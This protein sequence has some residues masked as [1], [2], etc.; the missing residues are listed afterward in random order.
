MYGSSRNRDP[1]LAM[2]LSTRQVLDV[3]SIT[4]GKSVFFKVNR[5]LRVYYIIFFYIFAQ[6]HCSTRLLHNNLCEHQ[7]LSQFRKL[8]L[9][10]CTET[11]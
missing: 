5:I 6:N 7:K 2:F 3:G 4:F 11:E 9:Q 10:C 8:V 1:K